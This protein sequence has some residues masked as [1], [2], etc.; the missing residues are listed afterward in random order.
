MFVCVCV[1]L[2]HGVEG[3]VCLCVCVLC[4]VMVLRELCL[5]VINNHILITNYL[6][7]IPEINV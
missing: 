3:G 6:I 7:I 5:C 4:Y 1:M 2:C